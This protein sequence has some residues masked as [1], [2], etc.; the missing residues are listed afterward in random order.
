MCSFVLTDMTSSD[1]DTDSD[2]SDIVCI[3]FSC[4][5]VDYVLPTGSAVTKL[6][7]SLRAPR[8]AITVTDNKQIS[9]S[10]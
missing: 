6:G 4:F 2:S 1:S 9:I 7:T 3:D 5:E 8:G 10:K